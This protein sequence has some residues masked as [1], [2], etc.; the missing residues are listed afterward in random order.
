MGSSRRVNVASNGIELTFFAKKTL[1]NRNVGA[2]RERGA[3]SDASEIEEK[4]ADASGKSKP[5]HGARAGAVNVHRNT[6]T[7]GYMQMTEMHST[8]YPRHNSV[9]RDACACERTASA[10]RRADARRGTRRTDINNGKPA[11]PAERTQG[12]KQSTER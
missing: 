9:A 6:N 2:E 3:M 1:R 4:T 7:Q 11:N 5:K 12:Q 8:Q 10:P